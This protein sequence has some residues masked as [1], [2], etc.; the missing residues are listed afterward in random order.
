MSLSPLSSSRRTLLKGLF[1]SAL[2]P[3]LAIAGIHRNSQTMQLYPARSAPELEKNMRRF[4]TRWI[5]VGI[6]TSAQRLPHVNLSL[7]VFDTHGLPAKGEVVV[8]QSDSFSREKDQPIV[9]ARVSI[10]AQGNAS[11]PLQFPIM[12][13]TLI[14]QGIGAAAYD[15]L[16]LQEHGLFGSRLLLDQTTCHAAHCLLPNPVARLNSIT[17]C[18][19]FFSDAHFAEKPHPVLPLAWAQGQAGMTFRVQ[20]PS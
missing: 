20:L 15:V 6:V 9:A 5:P 12:A 16:F 3:G 18:D 13:S 8:L 7:T 19:L 1:A 2:L 4:L 17:L 14:S 10:D 11:L